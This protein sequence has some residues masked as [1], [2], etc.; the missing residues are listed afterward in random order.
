M[1]VQKIS[2]RGHFASREPRDPVNA[3]FRAVFALASIILKLK[4]IFINDN[5][6]ASVFSNVQATA[7]ENQGSS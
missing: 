5:V 6:T 7:L 1:T 4:V 2:Q 3:T